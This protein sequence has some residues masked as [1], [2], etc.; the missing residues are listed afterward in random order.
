MPTTCVMNAHHCIIDIEK[1][2]H[3]LT[4]SRFPSAL[5]ERPKRMRI[6]PTAWIEQPLC[7]S[8]YSSL[9]NVQ[10]T[11]PM[12]LLEKGSDRSTSLSLSAAVS[13]DRSLAVGSVHTDECEM[14]TSNTRQT[15]TVA[16]TKRYKHYKSPQLMTASTYLTEPKTQSISEL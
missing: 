6:L 10:M 8:V 4:P 9:L 3:S 2:V 1:R 13:C 12:T 14:L 11:Q 15:Y 5:M 7:I 16:V